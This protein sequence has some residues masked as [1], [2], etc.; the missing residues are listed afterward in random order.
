LRLMLVQAARVDQCK[1]RPLAPARREDILWEAGVENV[2]GEIL[3]QVER[4]F[5]FLTVSRPYGLFFRDWARDV[6]R[7]RTRVAG[8]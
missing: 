8:L 3:G 4:D 5:H 2:H 1:N 7:G 6:N